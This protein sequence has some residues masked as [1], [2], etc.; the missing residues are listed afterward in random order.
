MISKYGSGKVDELRS[1]RTVTDDILLQKGWNGS[2]LL[3]MRTKLYI[4]KNRKE[5]IRASIIG[6]FG[7]LYK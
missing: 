2:S 1:I 4:I 6:C 7:N 5:R 3:F